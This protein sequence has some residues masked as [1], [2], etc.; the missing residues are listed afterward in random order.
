MELKVTTQSDTSL[1]A[2]YECPCGCAPAVA[3]TRGSGPV[4]EGCCC[5]NQFV[6]GPSAASKIR[7]KDGFHSE[8][9]I[10]AAPW[11]EQIEAAWAIGPSKHEN[12]S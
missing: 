11:G 3:Y 12:V 4:E 8:A 2:G 5:G 10:F 9:E 7:L 6:V 1:E